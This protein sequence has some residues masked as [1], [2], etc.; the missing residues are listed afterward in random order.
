MHIGKENLV[1][2]RANLVQQKEVALSQVQR[3]E[4]ALLLIDEII[5]FAEMP[6][7]VTTSKD[8]NILGVTQ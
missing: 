5:K 7:Q 4:G 8:K 6:E 3:F 1:A 2:T